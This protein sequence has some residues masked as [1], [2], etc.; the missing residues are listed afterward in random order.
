MPSR[1]A[2]LIN[3]VVFAN[4]AIVQAIFEPSKVNNQD[5]MDILAKTNKDKDLKAA[6]G[7]VLSGKGVQTKKYKAMVCHLVVASDRANHHLPAYAA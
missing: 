1:H 3:N 5:G 7:A 6:Q 4:E 2:S